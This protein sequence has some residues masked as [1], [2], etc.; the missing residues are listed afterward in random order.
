[1]DCQVK[2]GDD[3]EVAARKVRCLAPLFARRGLG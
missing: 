3:G 2:P 1:M